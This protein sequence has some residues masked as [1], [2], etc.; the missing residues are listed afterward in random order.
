M[1]EATRK[2]KNPMGRDVIVKAEL[3]IPDGRSF[4]RVAVGRIDERSPIGL[5]RQVFFEDL[6]YA[7]EA[8]IEVYEAGKEKYIELETGRIRRSIERGLDDVESVVS[9]NRED[10]TG[11][12]LT[13]KKEMLNTLPETDES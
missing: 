6:P 5:S 7:I 3:R 8:L 9:H 13:V 4:L 11:K 1:N 12:L 2:F 10:W